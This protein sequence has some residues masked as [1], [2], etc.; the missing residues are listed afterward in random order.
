MVGSDV[1]LML[2]RRSTTDEPPYERL[3]GDAMRGIG[4]LFGRQDVVEAQW[5]A[6]QPILGNGSP[7]YE[8]KPGSWGPDEADQLIGAFGPWINPKAPSEQ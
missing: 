7:L 4:D 2:Q 3:L 5:R 8:Y 1:E 6:V